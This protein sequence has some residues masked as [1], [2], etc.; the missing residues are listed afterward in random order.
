MVG[1][2]IALFKDTSLVSQ[3][4]LYE[5]LGISQSILA[6]PQYLGR[7]VEVYALV[8]LLYWSF[9]YALSH[10]SR[11]LERRLGVGER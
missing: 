10:L 4:G 3:F 5:L 8:A 1:Q 2:F 6:Q 9:S 11:R 7:Y